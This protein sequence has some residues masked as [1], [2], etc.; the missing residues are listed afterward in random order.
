[1]DRQG[2]LFVFGGHQAEVSITQR[3]T[4]SYESFERRGAENSRQ[5]KRSLASVEMYDPETDS[6][7]DRAPLPTPRQAMGAALGA[8]GRIYVVGGARSYS[9]PTPMGVVEIYDPV[10]DSWSEGPPLSHPR[11]GHQV[12]ATPEGRIYA[13]GG[14]VAHR[15]P[16]WPRKSAQVDPELG[17]SVEMLDTRGGP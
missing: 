10:A 2:R 14:W 16:R 15:A 5:G 3:K 12:V 4:E 1:M 17:A 13:I 6:W 11:R 8:D 9:N 7:S